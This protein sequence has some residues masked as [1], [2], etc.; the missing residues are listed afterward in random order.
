MI[1]GNR[2]SVPSAR[3]S[4]GVIISTAAAVITK[5]DRQHPAD[6]TLRAELKRAHRINRD[7][8]RLVSRAVFAFY[9]WQGWLD[10]NMP[11]EAR[12]QGAVELQE[13]FQ[14]KPGAM[15]EEEL[16][17]AVAEWV[18]EH[19]EVSPAWLRAIQAEPKLWV[20]ARAGQGTELA[21][22]LGASQ[23]VVTGLADSIIFKGSADLF[24]TDQF[25]AGKF[26]IQDLS[27]QVVG[28]VCNPQP[29]ETWWDA[30]AGEGGKTLHL[31]DLM[32]GRGLVWATDRAVW[33]LD[34]L[35]ERA[36]RASAFNYRSALW[37]G[38]AKLPTDT[39]FDGILVDAPCS[40]VG[41]WQRNPHARWTTTAAD[42]LELAAAQKQL[43]ANV[44]PSL[45]PGGRLIYSVCT[46]TRAETVEVQEEIS[47]KF[48]D[49]QPLPLKNPLDAAQSENASLTLWPQTAQGNGMFICG[50]L[51]P[52]P[53]SAKA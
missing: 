15:P 9:R 13:S 45:K 22:E 30:C 41:T 23:C 25:H 42:V 32:R 10:E 11:M 29:R 4:G 20:R 12:V 53:A 19:M 38:G 50:W 47:R 52:A 36:A 1:I 6:A 21:Q 3:Q 31:C 27:S 34:K 24:R 37:D 51:K 35:K 40:G 28:I 8:A 49:L 43:L 2:D 7:Q 5:S 46:L 17:L 18:S 14:K 39:K 44:I 16:K 33:R 48:P 26:E